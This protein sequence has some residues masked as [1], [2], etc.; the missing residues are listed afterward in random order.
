[1]FIKSI[2]PHKY[3]LTETVNYIMAQMT[4]YISKCLYKYQSTD[5]NNLKYVIPRKTLRDYS[6]P[7]I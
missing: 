1:M 2:N 7:P 6:I 5:T 3:T 4:T